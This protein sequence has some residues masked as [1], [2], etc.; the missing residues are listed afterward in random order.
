MLI[1]G[2]EKSSRDYK[3]KFYEIL[4]EQM[5]FNSIWKPFMPPLTFLTL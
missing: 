2:R 4:R 1:R 5:A 3:E